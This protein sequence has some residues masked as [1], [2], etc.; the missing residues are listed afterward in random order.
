MLYA[1]PL[2]FSSFLDI[3]I[4]HSRFVFVFFACLV[5]LFF[6]FYEVLPKAL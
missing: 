6:S 1:R 5:R 4:L 2:F 3:L